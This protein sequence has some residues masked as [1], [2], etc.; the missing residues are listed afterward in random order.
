MSEFATL[1]LE[2]LGSEFAVSHQEAALLESHYRALLKWNKVLN[3]TR[4]TELSSAV[5][6]HY[7]ESVFVAYQLP[8]GPLKVADVGSGAGF[9]G[10]PLGVVRQDVRVTLVEAHQRKAVFLREAT[11][12][13]GNFAVA[14]VRSESLSRYSFDWIVS[15][16]VRW[17]HVVQWPLARKAAVLM[18]GAD[19]E[20]FRSKAKGWIVAST[21][22]IPWDRES[23]LVV[24]CVDE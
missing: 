3:L 11:R 18:S 9:P 23:V 15:R 24:A 4:I 2:E 20:H 22:R 14:A 1:L 6:R 13:F 10:I 21:E 5:R 17:E 8:H 7:C 12:E 19:A 16:A